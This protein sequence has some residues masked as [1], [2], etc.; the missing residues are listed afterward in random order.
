MNFYRLPHKLLLIL[1]VLLQGLAP[2]AHA[3]VNADYA[4]NA[5]HANHLAL[6]ETHSVSQ[7]KAGIHAMI[8]ADHS[9]I[10]SMQPQFK[11]NDF[12]L[13]QYFSTAENRF[14]HLQELLVM[15]LQAPRELSFFSSPYQ[16]PCSQAP[17]L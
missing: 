15:H 6:L 4:D 8:D 16:H 1:F 2:V 11:S 7:D 9:T 14:E 13:D 3:H 12:A 17:P 5:D 10:V